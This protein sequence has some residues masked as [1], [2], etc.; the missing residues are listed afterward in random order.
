MEEGGGL[1]ELM[2]KFIVRPLIRAENGG[3]E[4]IRF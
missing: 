1:R 3:L 2:R 4:M